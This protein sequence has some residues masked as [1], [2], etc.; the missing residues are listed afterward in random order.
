MPNKDKDRIEKLELEMTAVI[1]QLCNLKRPRNDELYFQKMH[2]LLTEIIAAHKAVG[3]WE[4]QINA[5]E[6]ASRL[7]L[8][9]RNRSQ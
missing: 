8:E 6:A 7:L 1:Q 4:R 3:Q 2:D 9:M 5:V